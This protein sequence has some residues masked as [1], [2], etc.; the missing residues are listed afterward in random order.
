[1]TI[2]VGK[3][4]LADICHV[5][6]YLTNVKPKLAA[7]KFMTFSG[8]VCKCLQFPKLGQ[9]V[10][11]L[12]LK[13]HTVYNIH[14]KNVDVLPASWGACELQRSSCSGTSPGMPWFFLQNSGWGS[15]HQALAVKFCRLWPLF[16]S[17]S[18][19]QCH[20]FGHGHHFFCCTFGALKAHWQHQPQSSRTF[21]LEVFFG[22][23]NGL[24]VS[25]E[26]AI[27][28]PVP[29]TQDM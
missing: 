9:N 26:K 5:K 21:D 12:T 29:S 6:S 11:M 28:S 25:S 23:R 22:Q 15:S 7:R 19:N 1:M 2:C 14:V 8:S 24:K 17:N 20:C 16:G 13:F 27:L 18:P 3:Y 10:E 4:F